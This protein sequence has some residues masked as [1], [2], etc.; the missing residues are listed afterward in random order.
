VFRSGILQIE[1]RYFTPIPVATNSENPSRNP[2]LV[3][4]FGKPSIKIMFR[5]PP[6]RLEI[7]NNYAF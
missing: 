4:A 2:K 6:M 3:M 5:K 7:S 1:I